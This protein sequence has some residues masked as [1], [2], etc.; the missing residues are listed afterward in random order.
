MKKERRNDIYE[1]LRNFLEMQAGIPE[2][3]EAEIQAIT[4]DDSFDGLDVIVGHMCDEWGT[5]D[6]R[7]CLS[8]IGAD[9]DEIEKLIEDNFDSCF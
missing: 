7:E 3:C 4:P 9:E 1:E 5:D 8:M 6:T 2:E